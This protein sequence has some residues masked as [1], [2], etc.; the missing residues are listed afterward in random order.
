[1][2]R[3]S[4]LNGPSWRALEA[5]RGLVFIALLLGSGCSGEEERGVES[6]SCDPDTLACEGGLICVEQESGEALCQIPPGGGCDQEHDQPSCRIGS[7]CMRN[8]RATGDQGA[9]SHVCLVVEAGACDPIEPFC[10]EPL[11]CAEVES[12]GEHRC[13]A[14]L[15]V[16]GTV[17][18]SRSGEPIADAHVIA[19]DEE[20]IATTD[21]A[22]SEP[23]G[24]YELTVP[25]AR[26]EEGKPASVART[27]G[28]SPF[29]DAPR[30]PDT[31]WRAE[32]SPPSAINV[33]AVGA[34]SII[35][36]SSSDTASVVL[37]GSAVRRP[38]G[39]T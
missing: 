10:A 22:I 16:R 7:E 33:V 9:P 19:L 28:S 8:P 11:T 32:G 14:P 35:Q 12:T 4:Y 24:G 5:R 29:S 17:T 15:I 23:D 34:P 18:D 26:D 13:F 39:N 6:L 2:I 31:T 21:V 37:S 1:M 3:A 25:V 20:G 38:P 36:A 27:S 30:W